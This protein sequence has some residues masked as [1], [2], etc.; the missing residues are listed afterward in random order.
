MCIIIV[1]KHTLQ[2]GRWITVVYAPKDFPKPYYTTGET[3]R[4]FNVTPHTIQEWDR[5]GKLHSQRTSTNRRAFTREEIIQQLQATGLYQEEQESKHDIIYARVST[6]RQ[7]DQGDLDRQITSIVTTQ[8]GLTNLLV[9]KET[10]SGL[11]DKRKE[12]T[13]LLN[14]IL[15][16]KVNRVYVTYKDRLTRF[17]YNY[18]QTL[19]DAHNVQIITTNTEPT[20]SINEELVQDVMSLIASFSG[21]LYGLRSHKNKRKID[22]IQEV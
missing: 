6:K 2:Y 22:K 19:A 21:R 17:G 3:A 9:L 8:P 12:L 14:L 16:D 1:R 13:K 4:Y 18:I 20:T 15:Q 11:N 5:Q 7:A 10:G